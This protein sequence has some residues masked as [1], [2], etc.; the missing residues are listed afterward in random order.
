[1]SAGDWKAM[2][3]G[4]QENDFD[5]VKYYLKIDIDQHSEFMALPLAESIRYNNINITELLLL[6]GA[7]PLIKEMESAST[8][9]EITKKMKNKKAIDLLNA[10]IEL[11][12][13][14]DS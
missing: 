1:M 10:F 12:H 11:A 13:K 4:I 8:S 14:K 9:L 6:H 5:L 2:F 7:K 3:K